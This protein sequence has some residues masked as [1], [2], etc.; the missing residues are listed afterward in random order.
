VDERPRCIE[1]P[2]TLVSAL[3]V[4]GAVSSKHLTLDLAI[5]APLAMLR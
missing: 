4:Q 5:Q 3:E 2:R 1:L